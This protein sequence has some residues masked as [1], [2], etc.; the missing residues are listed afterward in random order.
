LEFES[1]LDADGLADGVEYA[2]SLDPTVA[3]AAPEKLSLPEDKIEISRDLPLQRADVNYAAEWSDGLST[4]SSE[5][6]EI[7]IEGG[8]IIAS[9]AKGSGSRYLR[10]KIEGQ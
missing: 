6:V 2:F 3:D 1:D 8:K 9:V 7:R 10:W 5:G 4:W